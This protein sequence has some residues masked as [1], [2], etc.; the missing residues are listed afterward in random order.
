MAR[1]SA[2]RS[3][4]WRSSSHGS[5]CWTRPTRAWTS[6][7]SRSSR[8]GV[9]ALRGDDLGV[10]IITHYT[11]ILNYIK[12]DVVHVMYEGRIAKTGGPE[13]ADHLESVG[14]IEFGSPETAVVAGA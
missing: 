3:C 5:P 8:K 4:R 2:T 12:P 14:Y 11:R 10:L 7:R 6:T 13:L 9:N 1:R